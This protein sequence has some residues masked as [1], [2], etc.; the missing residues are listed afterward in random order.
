V[1]VEHTET[2]R[3]ALRERLERGAFTVRELARELGQREG[4]V[5]AHLE[6]LRRSLSRDGLTL[7]IEPASCDRC[8]F[9]FDKRTRLGRPSRCPECRGERIAAPRFSIQASR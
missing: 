3:Q 4:D 8:G 9:E 5:V 1:P 6:H 7:A 2:A